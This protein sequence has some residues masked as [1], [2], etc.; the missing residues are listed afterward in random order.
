MRT[1]I[2]KLG[3]EEGMNVGNRHELMKEDIK[4]NVFSGSYAVMDF[5]LV[6]LGGG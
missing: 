1:R 5:V 6:L 4:L 2:A 3:D